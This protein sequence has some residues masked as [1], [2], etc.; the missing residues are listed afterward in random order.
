M[1]VFR[2]VPALGFWG[3]LWLRLQPW[4]WRQIERGVW[5]RR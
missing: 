3:A 2:K 4:K 5:M 1:N